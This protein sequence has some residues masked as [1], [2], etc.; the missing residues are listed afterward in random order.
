M[1]RQ[2]THLPVDELATVDRYKLMTGLVT[3][4]PIG[5]IGTRS[6]EGVTNLAPYSF[7]NG[8]AADPPT[9]YFSAGLVNGH[10]KDSLRNAEETGE[11]TVNIVSGDTAAAMNESSAS[12]AA[13]QSEFAATGLT[14]L[15]SVTIGA[16][17]VA[18]AKAILE[19][20]VVGTHTFGDPETNAYVMVLG[21]IQRFVVDD[22]V[23]DGTRIDAEVLDSVGRLA[24]NGY[25]TTRDRFTL[26]RPA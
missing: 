5:W 9:I 26:T 8:V 25:A 19:C 15:P 21:E 10:R 4:R 7:F 3:P 11:F 17:G 24:G 2:K 20:R 1:D 22:D 12:L 23:L 18:E 14:E 16:P 13:D 6:T